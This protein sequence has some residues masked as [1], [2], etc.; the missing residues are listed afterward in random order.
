M[1]K[2]NKA[3]K[4]IGRFEAD[5]GGEGGAVQVTANSVYGGGVDP[6]EVIIMR[7]IDP[8]HQSSPVVQRVVVDTVAG[9]KQQGQNEGM[10]GEGMDPQSTRIKD[11]EI[12]PSPCDFVSGDGKMIWNIDVR[13]KEFR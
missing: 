2:Q 12:L 3:F 10:H 4:I 1:Y 7:F 8:K 9:N 5:V 13:V 11:M 6:V